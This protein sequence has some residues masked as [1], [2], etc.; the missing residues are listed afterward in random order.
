MTNTKP[1]GYASEL[2][3]ALLVELEFTVNFTNRLNFNDPI[4]NAMFHMN[5][6]V[7][8]PKT[9]EDKSYNHDMKHA[10]RLLPNENNKANGTGLLVLT[11]SSLYASLLMAK[12]DDRDLRH[13]LLMKIVT[14]YDYYLR[15]VDVNNR[16]NSV[17]S[18][19]Q[20][21]FNE[22]VQAMAQTDATRSSIFPTTFRA[23]RE[24]H[25]ALTAAVFK[26]VFAYLHREH[27]IYD[28]QRVLDVLDYYLRSFSYV[29]LT[30]GIGACYH[31]TIRK[32]G[33][34]SQAP[35]WY[36]KFDF[37]DQ[38]TRTISH[39]TDTLLFNTSQFPVEN[40]YELGRQFA[41]SKLTLEQ[42]SNQH[43][44]NVGV[45]GCIPRSQKQIPFFQEH[46]RLQQQNYPHSI[47]FI[48]DRLRKAYA[49]PLATM[50]ELR[51]R[52]LDS[53]TN[54]DNPATLQKTP[55]DPELNLRYIIDLNSYL[56]NEDPLYFA[57][58]VYHFADIYTDCLKLPDYVPADYNSPSLPPVNIEYFLDNLGNP[59]S[60]AF[61]DPEQNAA[62]VSGVELAL[63]EHFSPNFEELNNQ[64]SQEGELVATQYQIAYT[65]QRQQL[66]SG[67]EE[68]VS[69][70]IAKA[71]ESFRTSRQRR[72]QV[73][74]TLFK[75]LINGN[76]IGIN[77]TRLQP[78]VIVDPLKII[79]GDYA[80]FNAA[81]LV[82][83]LE[84]TAEQQ[85]CEKYGEYDK[86]RF[87]EFVNQY[88]AAERE[89]QVQAR[90]FKYNP[91]QLQKYI[92]DNREAQGI[93]PTYLQSPAYS[94]FLRLGEVAIQAA[95]LE[96]GFNEAI[97]VAT[98]ATQAYLRWLYEHLLETADKDHSLP[99]TSQYPVEQLLEH[100]PS[101]VIE[102]FTKSGLTE[103][104][105]INYI[106][107]LGN[108]PEPKLTRQSNTARNLQRMIAPSIRMN[109]ATSRI[110]SSPVE[111]L[112]QPSTQATPLAAAIANP[113][114]TKLDPVTA[115]QAQAKALAQ[116]QALA[117]LHAQALNANKSSQVEAQTTNA[118]TPTTSESTPKEV[119]SPVKV[120]HQPQPVSTTTAPTNTVMRMSRAAR[121]KKGKK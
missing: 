111:S 61:V 87:N 100:L 66:T 36:F 19:T 54:L 55:Y 49:K 69:E 1:Y 120:K 13:I 29:A 114:A 115:A 50:Q 96:Q 15:E 119:A 118:N 56:E 67:F 63:V 108:K 62:E 98:P 37:T 94:E 8:L 16:Y 70:A 45:F 27:N 106:T 2:Q 71:I 82:K 121:N 3:R 39:I 42:F 104:E 93:Y 10:F 20:S 46:I 14:Y 72:F 116:A 57:N 74:S 33:L 103:E 51:E 117:Q 78:K 6:A 101:E 28:Q 95:D 43:V 7:Y 30:L 68:N 41:A 38:Q 23:D 53:V 21:E 64:V 73:V 75:S 80:H 11:F 86:N 81:Q 89:L 5:R 85:A 4:I 31:A 113:L 91:R 26:F 24:D 92:R 107:A 22:F 77:S 65:V 83:E 105:I 18:L 17:P 25:F 12:S 58:N 52:H 47:E 9:L 112:A 60:P 84:N 102:R 76:S 97:A 59:V 48:Q 32:Y 40:Y 88:L 35:F 99:T 109:Q 44:K 79:R 110:P 34:Q 90:Q